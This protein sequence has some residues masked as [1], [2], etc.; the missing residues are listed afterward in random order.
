MLCFLLLAGPGGRFCDFLSFMLISAF[1]SQYFAA[2]SLAVSTYC[3]LLH[4]LATTTRVLQKYYLWFF[5]TIWVLSFIFAGIAWKIDGYGF[6]AGFCYLG[7][8]GP[9]FFSDIL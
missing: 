6:N 1:W 2:I 7:G 4:P 9:E 3:I 5:P 8:E